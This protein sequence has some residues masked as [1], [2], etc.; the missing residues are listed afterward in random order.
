MNC[1]ET[2]REM[3]SSMYLSSCD[4]KRAFD[5]L[6]REFT[7][8]SLWR[9]GVPEDIA[10]YMCRMDEYGQAFVRTPGNVE[11]WRGNKPHEMMGVEVMKVGQ[12]KILLEIPE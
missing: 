4:M 5:S 11:N 9:M 6:G 1:M 10:T 12:V 3:K 8:F 2:V 7:V